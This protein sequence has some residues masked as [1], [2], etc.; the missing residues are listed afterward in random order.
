M[1]DVPEPDLTLANKCIARFR[2]NNTFFFF[3]ALGNAMP[4]SESEG[5]G[6]HEAAPDCLTA[7]LGL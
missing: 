4:V 7:F 1:V 2:G 3:M 5:S 6:V